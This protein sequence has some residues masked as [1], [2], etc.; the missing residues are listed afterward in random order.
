[1]EFVAGIL[2]GCGI[3]FVLGLVL[4]QQ[5]HPDYLSGE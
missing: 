3:G 5:A 1:M 2:C 4:A